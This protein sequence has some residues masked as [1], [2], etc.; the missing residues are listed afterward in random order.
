MSKH[1]KKL[2][3]ILIP[4]CAGFCLALAL[5]SAE[6]PTELCQL[7]QNK[8]LVKQSI[9][10]LTDPNWYVILPLQFDP[11]YVEH[12]RTKWYDPAVGDEMNTFPY[13]LGHW[14]WILKFDFIIAEGDMVAVLY[15][16]KGGGWDDINPTEIDMAL[17]RIANGK[18][19][20]GWMAP[21]VY[22]P[23]SSHGY[24]QR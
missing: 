23:P 22:R 3:L 8:A 24:D 13:W 12:V 9:L 1:Y 18:I 7:C 6:Q 14:R 16:W 2:I 21:C 15:T 5:G 19:V 11:N 20:E 10:D 4:A 17:Y